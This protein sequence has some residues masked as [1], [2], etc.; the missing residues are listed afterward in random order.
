M[1][2]GNVYVMGISSDIEEKTKIENF[3]NNM[4]DIKKLVLLVDV[5]KNKNKNGR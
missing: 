2:N 4:N 1:V 5:E 3:L